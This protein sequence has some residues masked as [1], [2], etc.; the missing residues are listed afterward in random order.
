AF[1][2]IFYCLTVIVELMMEII[3]YNLKAE[4][5]TCHFFHL[6]LNIQYQDR[7]DVLCYLIMSIDSGYQLLNLNIIQ[8]KKLY[9]AVP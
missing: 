1:E 7:H 6:A 2:D 3:L 8:R 4:R 9:H 5:I